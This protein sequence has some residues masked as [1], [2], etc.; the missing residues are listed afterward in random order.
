MTTKAV[1]LTWCGFKDIFYKKYFPEEIRKVKISKFVHLVQGNM[2]VSDYVTK[3]EAL[4]QF[5]TWV[6]NDEKQ[7]VDNFVMGLK[8]T[9]TRDVRVARVKEYAEVVDMAMISERALAGVQKEATRTMLY[10]PS[11][12]R[13]PRTPMSHRSKTQSSRRRMSTRRLRRLSHRR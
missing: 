10:L 8:A 4:S 1:N 7:K 2:S 12:L 6:A 3:F 13:R 5:A 9:I 11:L